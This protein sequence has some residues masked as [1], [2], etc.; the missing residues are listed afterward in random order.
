M[1]FFFLLCKPLRPPIAGSVDPQRN[2]GPPMPVQF[3]PVVPTQQ[4][5]QFV[6]MPS[7]HYQ[8]VGHGVPMINVGMPPQNQPPQ[9]SQPIQ[10]LPP[11]PSQQ[12]PLPSQAI[13]LPIARPN[14]QISSESMMPQPDSQ[15]PNGYA[16]GLGGPGV[17]LSSSYTSITPGTTAQSNGE[18]PS[19]TTVMPSATV[20]PPLAKVGSSDWIEH[21]SAT[22]RRFYYNKKTKLSS[23]EKP[24]ELMTP[25]EAT[26]N[27]D[28]YV[29]L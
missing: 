22:G 26:I 27:L 12:L 3:R 19:V 15:A 24:F 1:C 9:F 6:P 4:P 8:P 28:F 17:P 14:M 13:P 25:I 21:T 2:F 5:Q 20:Q 23:W 16:P 7:Q 29:L 10:P 11:R 18:Q